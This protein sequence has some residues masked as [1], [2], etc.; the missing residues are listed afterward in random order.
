MPDLSPSQ[1]GAAAEAEV[2]AAAIRADLVILR[3]LCDGGRYDLVIDVGKELLRV[4]CKWASQQRNVIV[5]HCMTSRH[6]PRGYLRTTYSAEEMD[7]IAIYAPDTDKC[8]LV[9]IREVEGL[10][11][12]S[13]R[14]GPTGNNQ[15]MH[16]RWARDYELGTSLARNW[17]VGPD[18]PAPT[19]EP[20]PGTL[21]FD[22]PGL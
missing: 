9:P 4:Q 19:G 1:K 16:V 7:A 21:R 22:V 3:P 10:T 14:V 18:R 6:T 5:A 15:A 2:A 8:Y 11:M 12:I 20:P 13:L 17:E